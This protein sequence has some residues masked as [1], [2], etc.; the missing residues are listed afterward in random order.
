MSKIIFVSFISVFFF[1]CSSI[2]STQEKWESQQ[3]K[4]DYW[5][6][7]SI[8]DKKNNE[9]FRVKG[10]EVA[11]EEIA[12]QI[13]IYI[14]SEFRRKLVEKNS[15]ITDEVIQVLYAQVSNNLE[16][17]DIIDTEN[18]KG[19]YMVFARLSKQKYY[20]SVKRKRE[21]ATNLALE[22]LSKA[23]QPSLQTFTYLSKARDAIRP[24]TDY[25]IHIQ[26]NGQKQNLYTL[27]EFKIEDMLSQINITADKD[28][29]RVKSL[30][31]RN[32]EITIK[33]NNSQTR[34]P[35][36]NI[37]LFFK[38]DQKI[39][40]CTT[41]IN[42]DCVF[43]VEN[44]FL[45]KERSQ[46]AYIGFD[47]NKLYGQLTDFDKTQIKTNVVIE[48]IKI[49]LNIREDNL[50][51]RLEYSY[52]EPIIKKFLVNQFNVEFVTNS[53]DYDLLINIKASV[54]SDG[55]KPNEYGL[56]KVFGQA[57]IDV[58]F[59]DEEDS[60]INLS[61]KKN[62]LDFNSF[63]NAGRSSLEKIS[64]IILDETLPE[65]ISILQQS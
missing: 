6:G 51:K 43:Y 27:I 17:V 1:N 12:S 64:T 61:I 65:L 15:E 58:K 36:A 55:N 44:E 23:E 62:G 18:L 31:D 47:T 14:E 41:D 20:A 33:C 8:I 49:L 2:N 63:D 60:L 16:D 53:L 7:I 48:P 21:N 26:Y 38:F 39:D 45:S 13:Q 59:A 57:D 19:Y 4:D 42:G 11:T 24:Y 30:I 54:S 22:Y 9:E 32:N 29:L 52:I 37:P 25:P 50:N 5:Y 3:E 10:R 28:V 56:Y 46:S 40:Y 35:I 34:A